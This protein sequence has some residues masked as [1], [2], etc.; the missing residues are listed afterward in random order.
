MIEI[1][2]LC[3]GIVWICLAVLVYFGPVFEKDGRKHQ[4]LLFSVF[5]IFFGIS[6]FIEIKTGGWWKPWWLLIWKAA[7]LAGIAIIL[8]K[9]LIK[10]NI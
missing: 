5:L 2:N 10:E 7:C 1:F 6:D 8:T 4:R 9:L 3:E